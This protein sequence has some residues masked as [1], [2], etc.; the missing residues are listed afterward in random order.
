MD[1]VPPHPHS[2]FQYTTVYGPS[3]SS[4]SVYSS[5]PLYMDLLSPHPH[6]IFQYTTVYGPSLSSSS[7][8]SS[9]PLYMDLL[10]PHPHSIFQYTTVYGPTLSSSSQY[11]PVVWS[12]MNIFEIMSLGRTRMDPS[13]CGGCN[14]R[15]QTLC[16]VC[17]LVTGSVHTGSVLF[18]GSLY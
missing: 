18:T 13:T 12:F 4:S 11:I 6:S 16:S 3:L 14:H 10:S 2:I 17:T 5:I 15:M 7:V 1:L 9:I 8:Y